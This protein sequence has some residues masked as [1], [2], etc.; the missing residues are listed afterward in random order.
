MIENITLG[1]IIGAFGVITSLVLI[2]QK[3]TGP[4]KSFTKRVDDLE[5]HADNDNKRLKTIEED[6]K[7]MLRSIRV[8]IAHSV[9]NNH[10][11]ELKETQKEID[12]YLIN[13]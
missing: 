12:E 5:K 1:E 2:Y 3:V 8:L 4:I 11:G 13:K 6:N 9:D 10:T 7:M